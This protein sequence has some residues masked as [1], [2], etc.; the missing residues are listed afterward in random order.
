MS[1]PGAPAGAGIALFFVDYSADVLARAGLDRSALS[2]S[3]CP[4]VAWVAMHAKE[5]ETCPP[6]PAGVDIHSFRAQRGTP[7][8]RTRR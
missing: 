1:L 3:V 7:P 5:M 2:A 4:A 6:L 8:C